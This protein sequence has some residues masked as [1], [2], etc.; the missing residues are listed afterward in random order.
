MAQLDKPVYTFSRGINT[1]GSYINFPD[2][3]SVDEVNYELQING[4]RRRKKGLGKETGEVDYSYASTSGDA[5]RT[6]KWHRVA[7]DSSINWIIVQTGLTLHFY[8]DID[9]MSANKS[10]LTVDLSLYKVETT[11][12]SDVRQNPVDIFFGRGHAFVLGKYIEPFY[13]QYDVD[14]DTITISRITI[15]ERDFQ[16]IDDGISNVAI[17][18]TASDSHTYNLYNRGWKKED[19]DTYLAGQSSYPTKA[20]IPWLGYRRKTTSGVAE[21]DWT[22]EF[23]DDK[24]VAELFQD[25]PAPQG[26]FT[27]YPFDTSRVQLPSATNSIPIASWSISDTTA[28]TQTVTVNTDGVHGLSSGD[29]VTISGNEAQY[30]NT[31]F[32]GAFPNLYIPTYSLDGDQTITVTDTDTF[33]FTVNFPSGFLVWVNQTKALG[34]VDT[35]LIDNPSGYTSA[36]RPRCGAFYAG[37]AWYAGTQHP[38]LSSKV[39]FSQIVQVDAQYGKCYQVADPTDERISDILPSDGGVIVIPEANDIIRLIAVG[40]VLLVFSTNGVWQ[41]GGS[42]G[43]FTATSYS[44]RKISDVGLSGPGAVAIVEDGLPYFASFNDIF[45]V[46]QDSNTGFLSC[47]NL[48]EF[49]IHT[50]YSSID[51]DDK[52]YIQGLYDDMTKRVL[53]LCASS[54]S[55]PNY[56]YDLQLTYDERL[57]AWVKYKFTQS[58]NNYITTAVVLRQSDIVNQEKKVK[59][60]CAT[61]TRTILGV[62]EN[63]DTSFLDF[64]TTEQDAYLITGYEVLGDASKWKYAPYVWVFSGKTETGYTTAGTDYVPVRESSTSFQYRWDWA[65]NSSSGKWGQSQEVYRHRR[66]YTPSDSSDTFADGTPVVVTR[67]KVRGRGRSLHFKFQA[68]QGKDSWLLGWH[69]KYDIPESTS[70]PLSRQLGGSL[71]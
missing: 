66:L 63:N 64:S 36:V 48:T 52:P 20:M 35:N 11:S 1:E 51:K 38:K 22:K 26:H 13:I 53:F 43:Y 12:D 70:T 14:T 68:G 8:K 61:N 21:N 60:I 4:S 47:A 40:S 2:N 49:T 10:A 23:S 50:L 33:T 56:A 9:S 6:F 15:R 55:V 71:I 62:Y 45:K 41:I 27:I 42:N 69:I 25:A 16:G 7:G 17:V 5:A 30:I 57:Q 24:L 18:T 46:T 34:T 3:C 59:Y 28:G 58:D 32:G 19:L 54:T 67:N 39:Y 44:V 29:V 65:D 37:R 31:G